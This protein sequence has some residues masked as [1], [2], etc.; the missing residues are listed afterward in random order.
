MRSQVVFAAWVKYA[1][2]SVTKRRLI[3][4]SK[5][6]YA[7]L[8][9]MP[10]DLV[11]DQEAWPR[12]VTLRDLVSNIPASFNRTTVLEFFCFRGPRRQSPPV[13]LDA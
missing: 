8:R 6:F 11:Q 12:N 1:R 4:D 9:L 13:A 10:K 5:S 7:G 3:A 2:R